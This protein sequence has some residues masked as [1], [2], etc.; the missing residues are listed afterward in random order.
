V[1]TAP[2]DAASEARAPTASEGA[3][4]ARDPLYALVASRAEL[5]VDD[6]DALLREAYDAYPTSTSRSRAFAL[7]AGAASN[8]GRH[9]LALAWI[10][11]AIREAEDAPD[12]E[13]LLAARLGE[14]IEVALAAGNPVLARDYT[15]RAAGQASG[16]R[17]VAA[18]RAVRSEALA[19][20]CP[21]V[22]ADA[23]IRSAFESG[24]IGEGVVAAP[25][26]R[27]DYVP[28]VDPQGAGFVVLALRSHMDAEHR[29]RELVETGLDA[30]EVDVRAEIARRLPTVETAVEP[31][32]REDGKGFLGYARYSR[33]GVNEVAAFAY[34]A[35][36]RD[37]VFYA[38]A[39]SG[40]VW[41]WRPAALGERASAG[42]GAVLD[43]R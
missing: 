31:F 19:L 2:L 41:D 24:R 16:W 3:G 1:T 20:E 29:A 27:C 9:A 33:P 21:D 43:A 28:I 18:R 32:F 38:A 37:G 30:R 14:A 17:D 40:P 11:W 35:A 8:D 36:S 5:S 12:R 4:P 39:A 13:A 23:F 15:R 34:A 6:A 7:A 25:T 10:D 26:A 22:I 42:L